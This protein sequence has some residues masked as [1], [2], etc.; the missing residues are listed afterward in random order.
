MAARGWA[1]TSGCRSVSFV[2]TPG[3]GAATAG[4]GSAGASFGGLGSKTAGSSA[5]HGYGL[6]AAVARAARS[7]GQRRW[8]LGQR[9]RAPAGLGLHAVKRGAYALQVGL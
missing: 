2:T 7:P 4:G 1:V 9:A 8:P 3:L 5:V 6:L